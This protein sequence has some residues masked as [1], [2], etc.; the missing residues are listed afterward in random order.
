MGET[1]RGILQNLW[2]ASA[3]G[4]TAGFVIAAVLTYL[5]FRS[6]KPK[7]GDENALRAALQERRRLLL[8][9]GDAKALA[10][11]AIQRHISDTTFLEHLRAQPC[12]A[13]LSPHFSEAFHRQIAECSGVQS[14]SPLLALACRR[15]IDQ[16]EKTIST[17]S[18]LNV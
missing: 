2:A 4:A 17:S 15:E 9:C 3:I 13:G 6:R 10:D 14:R 1:T 5:V 16:L 11:L 18:A 8:L 12:Y 7:Q